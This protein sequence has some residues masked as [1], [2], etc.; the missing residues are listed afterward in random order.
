LAGTPRSAAAS[1]HEEM[2]FYGFAGWSLAISSV[3]VQGQETNQVKAPASAAGQ[4]NAPAQAQTVLTNVVELPPVVITASPLP[5]TLFDLA[6]PVTVLSGEKLNEKLAPTL[7]ETVGREPGITSTYFGPNASR[8]IIR[9]L[10]AD[11]IRLL[12]NGVGNMDVSDLAPDHTVAQDPLTVTKIEVVRGPAAL[13]YGPT[14]VGGVVNVIDNRIPD[15][16]ISAPITGRVEGRYTSVDNGRNGAGV[17]EGGYKGFNYHF[18]GF[19]HANDDLTIP[20]F[21]RSERLRMLQPLPPGEEEPKDTLP[22]SQAHSAGGVAGISYVWDKGYAG[23]SFQRFNNNYG[24]V[25]EPD[26]TDHMS[27][28]R[29]DLAG[30]FYEPV[31]LIQSVKWKFGRSEEHTSELQSRE[32]LVCRLLL[33]KKKKKL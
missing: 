2:K 8:P 26:V 4:T 5:S 7:G 15:T 31:S 27:Q 6:Q 22:N 9:G 10:D 29:F 33:E 24:T 18:D 3:I 12:Q 25:A 30:A 21:A 20:G 23:G 17:V 13:L 16:R 28:S 19:L 11:H 32:N 14:A 1:I